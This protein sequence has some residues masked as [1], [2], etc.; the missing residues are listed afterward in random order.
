MRKEN[1]DAMVK[2]QQDFD[3]WRRT[4]ETWPEALQKQSVLHADEAKL[5]TPDLAREF[6]DDYFQPVADCCTFAARIWKMVEERL[7]NVDSDEVR[8]QT[9]RIVARESEGKGRGGN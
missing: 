1:L 6:P 8:R 4:A 2:S 5:W 9:A 7:A 3:L